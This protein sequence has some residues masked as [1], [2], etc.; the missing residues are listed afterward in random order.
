MTIDLYVW[1]APLVHVPFLAEELLHEHRAGST[2]LEPHPDLLAFAD[3][4][5]ARFPEASRE[6]ASLAAHATGG[7]WSAPIERSDRLVV[8]HLSETAPDVLLDELLAAIPTLAWEYDLVLFDPRAARVQAR[9]HIPPAP[10]PARDASRATIAGLVGAGL[11]VVASRAAIPVLSGGL[12]FIGGF[13]V[14][15]ALIS[16]PALVVAWRRSQRPT[17]DSRPPQPIDRVVPL[18]D[19]APPIEPE[20]DPPEIA[21]PNERIVLREGLR[22]AGWKVVDGGPVFGPPRVLQERYPP[23][24]ELYVAFVAG[25]IECVSPDETAWFLARGD[26]TGR[27]ESGFRWDECERMMREADTLE[28]PP[29]TRAFWD[30]HLPIFLTVGG[31]YGYLALALVGSGAA[32]A[33][34]PV[35]QGFAPDWDEPTEV[36]PSFAAFLTTLERKLAAKDL[37]RAVN[38]WLLI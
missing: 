38:D 7:A 22:R 21:I 6:A 33:W 17:V 26:F 31:D 8:L 18:P 25:L 27:S 20:D 29:A 23:L 35:R 10:F 2:R 28:E 9:W 14:V 11:I 15:L 32:P 36:S 30:R 19:P 5:V 4:L 16:L 13:V 12:I 24:P 1:K 37:Q 34:G 3:Q